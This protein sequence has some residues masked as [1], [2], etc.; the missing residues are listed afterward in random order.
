MTL[1][2]YWD[3]SHPGDPYSPYPWAK[4][5]LRG[6]VLVA[7]KGATLCPHRVATD[8]H[9]FRLD[10]TLS[11]GRTLRLLLPNDYPCEQISPASAPHSRVFRRAVRLPAQGPQPSC[12]GCRQA[13][14][15]SHTM[16]EDIKQMRIGPER[17]HWVGE[18]P[19]GDCKQCGGQCGD[20]DCG[21]HPAGCIFGGWSRETSYW[22]IVDG[23]EL[24]HGEGP[25]E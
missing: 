16:S 6:H 5:V 15:R 4:P 19:A 23:C 20:E 3:D 2:E 10:V 14:F 22:L 9:V 1:Q 21:I 11:C 17:R 24:Y 18:E 13:N 8:G 25:D 12:H 7:V